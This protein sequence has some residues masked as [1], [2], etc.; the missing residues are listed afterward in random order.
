LIGTFAVFPH[1]AVRTNLLNSLAALTMSADARLSFL[2]S[3]S[4][5]ETAAR[6]GAGYQRS[7]PKAKMMGVIAA[8]LPVT[9]VLLAAE[10]LLHGMAWS[11]LASGSVWNSPLRSWRVY[12]SAPS[13]AC[14]AWPVGSSLTHPYLRLRGRYSDRRDGER[15]DQHPGGG[16]RRGTELAH[17]ALPLPIAAIGSRAAHGHRIE[18]AAAA[19]KPARRH[20]SVKCQRFPTCGDRSNFLG[21][22]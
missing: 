6:L 9:A 11:S 17:W 7:I 20:R 8:L 2:H 13:P 4:V 18:G 10:T 14:S 19:R 22:H 3:I 16:D 1:R 15:P 12:W 21:G 5:A